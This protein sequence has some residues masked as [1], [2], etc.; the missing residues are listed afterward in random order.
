MTF[1]EHYG[2]FEAYQK[3]CAERAIN[4]LK[5]GK[6][7]STVACKT[8]NVFERPE[9]MMNKDEKE[10]KK[11]LMNHINRLQKVADGEETDPIYLLYWEHLKNT[12]FPS[13]RR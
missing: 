6:Y 4:H 5:E 8:I 9:Y 12:E 2:S 3:E 10:V 11:R 13:L 7:Y 1:Q